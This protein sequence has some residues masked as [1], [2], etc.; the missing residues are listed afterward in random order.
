MLNT[1]VVSLERL[2]YWSVSKLSSGCTKS[3]NVRRTNNPTSSKRPG[4]ELSHGS[5]VASVN[6]AHT[7]LRGHANPYIVG[8]PKYA[9]LTLNLRGPTGAWQ[10][11]IP[12][13]LKYVPVLA[14]TFFPLNS[15]W[16]TVTVTVSDICG[17]LLFIRDQNRV[18]KQAMKHKVICTWQH[19]P[20]QRCDSNCRSTCSASEMND[21][22]HDAASR[23]RHA[24]HRVLSR[25]VEQGCANREQHFVR[26]RITVVG[27]SCHSSDA[28][29]F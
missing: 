26:S 1:E 19:K 23:K 24:P 27:Y 28:Q 11:G 2:P 13:K 29:N 3:S 8:E 6:T 22:L 14:V 7:V 20:E 16:A 12:W 17:F 25:N 9:N 21:R 10:Y 5:S 15:P 4:A 18:A